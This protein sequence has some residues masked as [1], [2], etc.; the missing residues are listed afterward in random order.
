M[1]GS[2]EVWS[3]AAVAACSYGELCLKTATTGAFSW[4]RESQ[5]LIRGRHPQ[6]AQADAH[7]GRVR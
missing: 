4:H 1:D 7:G 5:T 3:L 6:D 2:I